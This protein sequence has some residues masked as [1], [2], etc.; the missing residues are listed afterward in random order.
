MCAAAGIKTNV[1]VALANAV[2]AQVQTQRLNDAEEHYNRSC[3][4][5]VFIAIALPK[6]ALS[7]QSFYKA[8]TAGMFAR[9]DITLGVNFSRSKQLPHHCTSHRHYCQRAVL[10]S[11][12]R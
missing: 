9:T 2:Q 10:S 6:L 12:P 7:R 4:L 1:D 11:W 5:L 3:L 8:S